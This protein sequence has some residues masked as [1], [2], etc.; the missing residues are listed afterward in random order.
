MNK[1]VVKINDIRRPK[2]TDEESISKILNI[3][4]LKFALIIFD[5]IFIHQLISA[6]IRMIIIPIYEGVFLNLLSTKDLLYLGLL[7]IG[8]WALGK[9]HKVIYW[10][11]SN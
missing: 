7:M 9:L 5:L 1:G 10:E 3:I 4:F 2:W 11:E 6:F 8:E